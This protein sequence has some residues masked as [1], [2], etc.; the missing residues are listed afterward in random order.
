MRRKVQA[1]K[2]QIFNLNKSIKAMLDHH[3]KKPEEVK[4]EDWD[5]LV[6]GQDK[7]LNVIYGKKFPRDKWPTGVPYLNMVA[8][9]KHQ[10][11]KK[12][13]TA[14]KPKRA[15]PKK[16]EKRTTRPQ[17]TERP[18]L[19]LSKLSL[20]PTKAQNYAVSP[21]IF[22]D[23]AAV[24]AE[25]KRLEHHVEKAEKQLTFIRRS[26]LDPTSVSWEQW[27]DAIEGTDVMEYDLQIVCYVEMARRRKEGE[28][29]DGWV[30][31]MYFGP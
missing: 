25:I 15:S 26:R 3:Q 17:R 14:K 16:V 5:Q 4:A 13:T 2:K 30:Y 11:A 7:K 19:H 6:D 1:W 21:S 31:G 24:V 28:E 27:Q 9:A 23:P 29:C 10:A 22:D 18:S 12:A 20:R 8:L